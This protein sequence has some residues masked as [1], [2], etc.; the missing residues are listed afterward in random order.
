MI[1]FDSDK[2]LDTCVLMIYLLLMSG[3]YKQVILSNEEI[4]RYVKVFHEFYRV[5]VEYIEIC[6]FL[7]SFT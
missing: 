3:W 2:I 5:N 1:S 7:D 6:F 4:C